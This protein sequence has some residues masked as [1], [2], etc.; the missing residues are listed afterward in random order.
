MRLPNMWRDKVYCT[1][2]K[3]VQIRDT[4]EKMSN[5]GFL[6]RDDWKVKMQRKTLG[7]WTEF[8]KQHK[9]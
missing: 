2:H 7:Q 8:N 3:E 1:D 6:L 5:I 4:L 9:I